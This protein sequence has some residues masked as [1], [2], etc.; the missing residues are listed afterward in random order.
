MPAEALHEDMG[1]LR[2]ARRC[3]T[4]KFS[5]AARRLNEEIVASWRRLKRLEMPLNHF[6]PAKFQA[7]L[8]EA[9][10][11]AGLSVKEERAP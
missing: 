6:G 10:T 2:G 3:D 1:M 8:A 7:T 5:T 4:G 11:C 9:R